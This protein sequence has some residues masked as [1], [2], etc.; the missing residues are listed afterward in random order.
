MTGILGTRGS[1]MLDLVVLGMIIIVPVMIASIY[2]VRSKRLYAYH[3]RIQLATALL[4]LVLLVGFEVEMRVYGWRERAA[5]SPLQV[6]GLWNDPVEWSLI[7]HLMF[8][9]PTFFLWVAVVIGAMRG[10]PRPPQPCAYSSSHRFWGRLAALGMTF[11]AMT[12]LLFYYLAF[13]MR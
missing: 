8:A 10:F 4:L 2:A 5:A 1:L 3:K 13:V 6:E 11:T 12:G 9:V 7:A